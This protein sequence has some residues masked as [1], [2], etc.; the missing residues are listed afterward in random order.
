MFARSW[1]GAN[2]GPI[3]TVRL[4]RAERRSPER[5]SRAIP[6]FHPVP[7]PPRPGCPRESIELQSNSSVTLRFVQN[8]DLEFS[9][10]RRPALLR[11][12]GRIQRAPAPIAMHLDEGR[13]LCGI[14]DSTLTD[15]TLGMCESR[16]AILLPPAKPSDH[17]SRLGRGLDRLLP[18]PAHVFT[19]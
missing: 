4:W 2:S 9:Q 11:S 7:D 12:K 3:G 14:A 6:P 8:I 13:C 10:K 17:P 16:N 18:K 19:Q 5:T 15:K 1:I